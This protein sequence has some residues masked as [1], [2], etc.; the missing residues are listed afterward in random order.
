MP[1]PSIF[2]ANLRDKRLAIFALPAII[3][4]FY[5]QG[6]RHFAYTPDQTYEYL[7]YA[8]NLIHGNGFGLNAAEPHYGVPGVL[9]MFLISVGGA[10]GVD[11]LL[12]A[13]A[14]DLFIAS[15]AL[16]LFFLAA[17]EAIRDAMTALF[18]TLAFSMNVWYLQWAGTG[19]ETS[20]AVAL[21]LGALWFCLRNEYLISIF[22]AAL[23][24]LVRPEGFLLFPLIIADAYMNH[25]D[26][27]QGIRVSAAFAVLYLC[28]LLPWIAF[29]LWKFGSA[30]PA[31]F[32]NSGSMG[33]NAIRLH[34]YTWL[35]ADAPVLIVMMFSI[36]FY[37]LRT[38]RNESDGERFFY[39]RQGFVALGW[40]IL[41][42]VFFAF[43]RRDD[44]SRNIP[45]I[46][47]PLVIAGF[48]Y[49]FH[50]VAKRFSE[51]TGRLIVV[52][53][54]ALIIFQNQFAYFEIAKPQMETYAQGMEYSL[55]PIGKWFERN[56]PPE[57]V[58]GASEVGAIAYYAN[59]R[60]CEIPNSGG[61][62]FD[63]PHEF[64]SGC[65][66]DYFVVRSETDEHT[67]PRE[68]MHPLVWRAGFAWVGGVPHPVYYTVYQVTAEYK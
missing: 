14:I 36:M 65:R 54:A 57:A 55:K 62:L 49:F 59:R 20:L 32:L 58:I 19:V 8:R 63:V 12:A 64:M 67:M 30:L 13:K 56:T 15:M 7:Q 24:A 29:A 60:V 9:W 53:V 22:I 47:A 5:V 68:G 43:V 41:L 6:A 40:C 52:L 11:L 18:A 1:H 33:M 42:M 17:Y 44:G 26:S 39:F 25:A 50:F 31:G 35:V 61:Q 10:L 2:T 38:E 34:F 51:R 23:F 3:L 4:L 37:V 16:V 21:L 46:S 48:T 27:R 28:F 45:L 66:A